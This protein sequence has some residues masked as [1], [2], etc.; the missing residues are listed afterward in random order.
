[1]KNNV[2][3]YWDF[4][5]NIKNIFKMNI[6]ALGKCAIHCHKNVHNYHK[7]QLQLKA[8][9]NNNLISNTQRYRLE[10]VQEL[11]EYWSAK[12]DYIEQAANNLGYSL[13]NN[14]DELKQFI[15]EPTKE[16]VAIG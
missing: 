1:M 3:A 7:E 2:D 4:K 14:W 5:G 11:M 15:D 16:P 10:T 6:K 8:L 9:E 12:L 13:P